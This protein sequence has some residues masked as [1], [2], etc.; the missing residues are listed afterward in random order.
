MPVRV[1]INGFGRIGRNGAR[2][3]SMMSPPKWFSSVNYVFASACTQL[4]A[5][6]CSAGFTRKTSV[7]GRLTSSPLCTQSHP[8]HPAVA[9]H[10]ASSRGHSVLQS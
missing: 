1:A 7:P 2:G 10:R 9:A 4:T 8:D 3:R 6:A 5:Y